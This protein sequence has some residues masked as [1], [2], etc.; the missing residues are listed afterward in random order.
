VSA[1]LPHPFFF[2]QNRLVDG[3]ASDFDREENAVDID[4]L[5]LTPIGRRMEFGVFAGPTVFQVKQDFISTVTFDETY[6]YDTATFTGV[7][8]RRVSVTKT[9]ANV[10]GE[11]NF[12]VSRSA[13]LTARVRY[14]RV[15]LQFPAA[16]GT[17]GEVTAGGTDIGAGVRIRF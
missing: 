4:A 16:E 14:S 10:G 11:F 1:A 13:S 9:G 2:N 3:K 17:S 6:P 5:W 12:A 15:T 7:D 8:T